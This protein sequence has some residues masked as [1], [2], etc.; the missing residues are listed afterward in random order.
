MHSKKIKELELQSSKYRIEQSQ[1]ENELNGTKSDSEI[2]SNKLKDME[3][4]YYDLYTRY[5]KMNAEF[6]KKISETKWR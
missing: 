4:K 5:L 3:Q 1:L 6:E 2:K